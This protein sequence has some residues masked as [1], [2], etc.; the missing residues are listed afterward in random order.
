MFTRLRTALA[1]L[2]WWLVLLFGVACVVLGGVLVAR[3]FDSLSVLHWLVAAALIVTGVA[4]IVSASA[5]TRPWLSWVT[6]VG[7]IVAGVL[8]VAW[9]GITL[10]ALAVV[11]GI[12]LLVGGAVRIASAV[13]GGGDERFIV[14]LGG[15]ASVVVGLLV[16]SW[17]SVTVLVLAVIVGVGTA[18]FGFGQIGIALKLR[19]AP[20]GSVEPGE[21]AREETRWPMWVRLTGVIVVL[22]LAL[23]GA[24][25]SAAIHRA[26]PDAPPEFYTAPSPLPDGPPGTIIRSEVID[27]FYQ[28]ATAYRVLYTSTGYDGDPTAVSGIIVVPDGSAPAEGRKVIAWTHGTVGV[29][30]KCSPSL[31][32]DYGPTLAGIEEFMEAGS[33]IAAT[34]YQGLGTP[35]PHPYL[36][37]ESEGVG[38]L[39]SVR[40]ARNLDEADASAD[41]VVWGESQGGQASLFTGQLA[42][43]YAPELN[44][45]GVV[46]SAPA[47]DLVDL[48][49]AKSGDGTAVGKILVSMAISSWARVY[50]DA[51]LNQILTP[52]ARP[53]VNRIA[54]NCILNPA[55]IL[56]S[57]PAATALNVTFLSEPPWDTEPWTRIVAENTPGGTTT[58]APILITQG[59]ADPIISPNIQQQFVNKLCDSGNTVDYRTYPGIGHVT[60]AHDTAPDVVQWISDRFAGKP[61]PNT[62]P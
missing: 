37:G 24:A 50:D 35:G 10:F 45:V 17:P 49:K 57:V 48:F 14:G 46:A 42:S 3:P 21:L 20:S 47:S 39:D 30:S 15:L 52:A 2:P 28:G 6:G 62:C 19:G 44:L 36:V 59:E 12:A 4:E 7:W 61:A 51:E 11:I 22:V 16:L 23:G 38:A 32:P 55:Q 40:A 54:E 60:A 33:V 58:G 34:D 5:S 1:R 53:L 25:I 9:P 41:F 18:V 8:A 31:I 27:D 56:A 26:Q 13:F 29:A 43:T